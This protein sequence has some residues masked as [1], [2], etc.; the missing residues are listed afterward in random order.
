MKPGNGADSMWIIAEREQSPASSTVSPATKIGT[1]TSIK[2]PKKPKTTETLQPSE[3]EPS[4]QGKEGGRGK[5]EGWLGGGGTYFGILQKLGLLPTRIKPAVQ[6]KME[7][8]ITE[9]NQ[10]K[11]SDNQGTFF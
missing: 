6:R 11:R 9:R 10:P 4:T 3:L 1:W 2:L 8:S 5:G 7:N